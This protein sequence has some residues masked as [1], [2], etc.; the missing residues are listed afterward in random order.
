MSPPP[1]SS[2]Q[3]TLW[4][5]FVD[6]GKLIAPDFA[7]TALQQK[8]RK[9]IGLRVVSGTPTEEPQAVGLGSM[10][11]RQSVPSIRP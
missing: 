5:P 4:R 2:R 8:P 11:L 9:G 3:Q 10:V 6:L 7:G 1:K